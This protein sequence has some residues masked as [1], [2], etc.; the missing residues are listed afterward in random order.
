MDALWVSG[1]MSHFEAKR[2]LK[3]AYESLNEQSNNPKAINARQAISK[4]MN[5]RYADRE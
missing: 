3:R 4:L 5:G 1:Q 2:V